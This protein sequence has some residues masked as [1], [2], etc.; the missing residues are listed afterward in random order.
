MSRMQLDAMLRRAQSAVA[1]NKLTQADTIC[2]QLIQKNPRSVSTLNLLGQIA[3]A[4]SFYDLAAE[5]L[6]KSIAISPRDTRAHLILGEL[7]SFQ[8]RYED[9][10]ARYDKVLRLKPD[11]PSAIAGKADTW[12]KCGER[13]KARA[14]LEPFITARQETPTMALVQAR[15]DLHARD[16]EAIVELVN[17]HLQATGY[18]LW[19]LLSVQGKALEKLGRFDEA[20]DAYRR[21][22]EAVSVPF[23]EHTWLQHTRDLIDNFSAQRLETLPRASHGSTV[24]VFIIGMPRSGSTLIETIIDTHPDAY[25]IGEFPAIQEIVNDITLSIE[26][27]SPYPA[28]IAD[29]DQHDVDTLART[30]LDRATA[31]HADAKRIADKY[32]ISFRHLGLIEL[33]FPDARVIHCLRDPL[34]TCISC[35]SQTLMPT[36]FPFATDLHR[37]GVV[38]RDYQRLMAHW[39][40]VL[41]I[42]ILEVRYEQLVSDQEK[43]SREI[44]EFCGL[45]WDPACLKYYERGRVVQTASYDQVTRP[46]YNSSVGRYKPFEKHLGPLIDALAR[47]G[48]DPGRS[49]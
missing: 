21:S 22:N 45:D 19:H 12:E 38:Y 9:A 6:E 29:L 2:E 23:D 48:A 26:S 42:P 37:L 31:G 14:L 32:L 1:A 8:G 46:I 30:Y 43:V 47:D 49:E 35:Y 34:D 7:R 41:K 18:S 39:K 36:A 16:H 3:F 24:P 20:F 17:R 11:E 5:H 13:D 15:L 33:L 4:R 44:I 40:S 27:F 10:I 28:C 25:G